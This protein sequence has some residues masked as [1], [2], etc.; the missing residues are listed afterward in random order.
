[1]KLP[2]TTDQFLEIFRQYNQGVFPFQF[3]FIL[4][5]LG[6]IILAFRPN[7]NSGKLI[8]AILALLWF[9]M[10]IIYH[11]G[12]FSSINKAAYVF[13]AAF[14]AQG[15]LFLAKGVFGNK[16]SF[17]HR[18][19]NVVWVGSAMMLYSLVI[20]P[21]LGYVLGHGYPASP[22]FGLPCPTTIFTLGILLWLD[23]KPPIYLISIPILWS[24]I[25]TF[26]AIK[27]GIREDIGLLI[28][29]VLT[30][31]LLSRNRPI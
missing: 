9:W 20:Y 16:L 3:L 21:L 22:T 12:Y 28:S 25:G 8:A 26:A 13:G 31:W 15:G 1:M 10:G 7:K 17:S 11:W 29:G 4:L 18:P 19:T 24:L 30:V 23:K 14:V 6:A 27:L 2:F 5:A